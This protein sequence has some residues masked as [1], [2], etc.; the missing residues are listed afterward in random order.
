MVND[1]R[2]QQRAST[3]VPPISRRKHYQ[4]HKHGGSDNS[5]A[6]STTNLISSRGSVVSYS[7]PGH[8]Q[9]AGSDTGH[10]RLV[11]KDMI[12]KPV[13]V[14]MDTMSVGISGQ[15]VSQSRPV[16]RQKLTAESSQRRAITTDTLSDFLRSPVLGNSLTAPMLQRALRK[17]LPLLPEADEH[18]SPLNPSLANVPTTRVTAYPAPFHAHTRIEPSKSA[19]SSHAQARNS[20][21]IQNVQIQD[22]D[23]TVAVREGPHHEMTVQ[24]SSS[25]ANNH[26]P[27]SER[28]EAV[29]SLYMSS[30][31]SVHED[32]LPDFPTTASEYPTEAHMPR[33]PAAQPRDFVQPAPPPRAMWR[34][35]SPTSSV[36][37]STVNPTRILLPASARA[38]FQ[39]TFPLAQEGPPPTAAVTEFDVNEYMPSPAPPVPVLPAGIMNSTQRPQPTSPVHT[40]VDLTDYYE[41]EIPGLPPLP[42]FRPRMTVY[43]D[44]ISLYSA[45]TTG[46]GFG[47][48]P[49]E[50]R[51]NIRALPLP[52]HMRLVVNVSPVTLS[53]PTPKVD[54]PTR[55]FRPIP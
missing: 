13:P 14:D 22:V 53:V 20:L 48:R 45:S 28:S 30:H 18:P 26:R 2:S 52:P 29:I 9:R 8:F 4:T 6:N 25:P 5:M 27:P 40:V 37:R 51:S 21:Q 17:P 55:G 3:P 1:Q 7:E 39:E 15:M 47:A 50:S 19:V 34:S 23:H 36:M 31:R 33:L 54:R 43:D 24:P 16:Q 41:D 42:T 49:R 46:W 11:T 10:G 44:E 32:Q 38:P 12:S 35:P